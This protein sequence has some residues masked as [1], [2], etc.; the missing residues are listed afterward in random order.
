MS[1]TVTTE[2]PAAILEIAQRLLTQDNR[3]TDCPIF[4]VQE[5]RRTYGFDTNYADDNVVWLNDP[6]DHVE[7]SPEEHARL[8][9]EWDEDG[10][11][12]QDWTRTAY[13]DTWE[14]VTSC[15]TE[16]GCQEYIRRNRHNH[17]GELRIYAAGSWRND[18]WRAV[19][20]W[21][22]AMAGP[23]APDRLRQATVFV[24]GNNA[25]GAHWSSRFYYIRNSN[26]TWTIRHM[27]SDDGAW[28][29]LGCWLAVANRSRKGDPDECQWE[30]EAGWAECERILREG[31]HEP[32]WQMARN[33]EAAAQEAA[34]KAGAS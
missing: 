15:F 28:S 26:G 30:F 7:A 14:H 11:E 25:P 10:K 6:N 2:I 17:R 12:P 24:F 3:A 27:P 16:T 23:A 33:R 8:E 5:K 21:L 19:R 9:A 31:I 22:V 32:G 1:R 18:E 34:R 13:Q 29:R 4:I 20:D